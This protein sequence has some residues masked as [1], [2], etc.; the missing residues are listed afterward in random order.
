MSAAPDSIGSAGQTTIK[1]IAVSPGIAIG[2][3]HLMQRQDLDIERYFIGPGEVRGEIGRFK[4]ALELSRRQLE[5][6]RDK[7]SAEL[8][9]EHS[10][11][12]DTHLLMLQDRM[13][14]DGVVG[15]I[16]ERLVNAESALVDMLEK[17]RD[18]FRRL[19]DDYIR[20][21]HTDIEDVVSRVMRNL[22]GQRDQLRDIPPDS[23]VVAVDLA[24]SET[25]QMDRTKVLGFL[26]ERGG[27]TSHT[28][29][30]ARS[31]EIPA[32]VGLAEVTRRVKEGDRI[33]VDGNAG[34]LL[35]NPAPETLEEYERYR[36]RYRYFETELLKIRERP[37][38]TRDGVRITLQGNIELPGEVSS[39]LEHG[40]EGVGLYR[41]EFLYLNR[42]DLPGIDE[43]FATYRKLLAMLDGRPVVIRT[44][45]LGGD[46]Y[47]SQIPLPKEINPA[48]GLR[49]IRLCLKQVEM[50]KDQLTGILMASHFGPIKVMFPMISGIEEL[51]R[52]RAV[53]DECRHELRSRGVPFDEEMKVGTMI[54]IP[55]AVT[56]ADLLARECDFFSIG[57]NDLI[58][59]SLAIDRVNQSVSYLYQPLHPA[60][61][62]ALR[63]V[64]AA[65]RTGG[66][67][68]A[69]CG[70]M[71]GEPLYTA[72][73]IGMGMRELSMNTM[74]IPRVKKIILAL[75]NVE[76]EVLAARA[77]EMATSA[78][79]ESFLARE[80]VERFPDDMSADGRQI[81]VL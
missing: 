10:Y 3:A 39:V 4:E 16:G 68:V 52:A 57:T 51:R 33:I 22:V 23:I 64:I 55:S 43:H 24:P 79:V 29:I 30:M 69:M 21:R 32:V 81:C 56:M 61:L 78:E 70:E 46:K 17:F 73:L 34:L 77:L 20:E 74:A 9:Q 11:I 80:M 49:A 27:K 45:D 7:L 37:A 47:V 54:E 6:I 62:R 40:G 15:I 41:T 8:G 60:V 14:V 36:S 26:T 18:A 38:V 66:I 35:I 58:Q 28:T 53:L 13:L 50:F 12:I 65:A 67:G 72:I 31:L 25:A 19:H 5:R 59:Y 42:N 71:A 1:G 44:L 2:R 63:T 75:S 76:A 48:L